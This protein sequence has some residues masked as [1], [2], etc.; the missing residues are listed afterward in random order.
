MDKIKKTNKKW[1]KKTK[2][3]KDHRN[4]IKIKR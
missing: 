1:K 3:N 2:N 4:K